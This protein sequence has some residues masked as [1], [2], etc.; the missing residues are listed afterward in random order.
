MVGLWGLGD[1][2]VAAGKEMSERRYGVVPL[3]H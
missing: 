1:V 2:I 3:W